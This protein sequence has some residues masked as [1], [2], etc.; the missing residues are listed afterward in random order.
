MLSDTTYELLDALATRYIPQ[1]NHPDLYVDSR[2]AWIRLMRELI[3]KGYVKCKMSVL[4]KCV[5]NWETILINRYSH[6]N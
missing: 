5:V 2:E 6:L 4:L 3:D 1:G